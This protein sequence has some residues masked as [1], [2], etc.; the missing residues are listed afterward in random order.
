M[1]L[2]NERLQAHDNTQPQ[3]PQQNLINQTMY[4]SI[5]MLSNKQK[6]TVQ[7]SIIS[8]TN[9]DIGK[10]YQTSLEIAKQTDSAFQGIFIWGLVNPNRDAQYLFFYTSPETMNTIIENVKTNL[11][12]T[13]KNVLFS[14]APIAEPSEKPAP[15]IMT[16]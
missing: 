7:L 12:L 4:N 2:Q 16:T 3:Q 13:S 9:L 14:V 10:A 11:G 8:L 1:Q 15:S 6:H 5:T